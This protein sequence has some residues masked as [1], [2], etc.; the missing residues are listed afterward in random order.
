MRTC[1][2]FAIVE[3]MPENQNTYLVALGYTVEHMVEQV[4]AAMRDGWTLAGGVAVQGGYV[5]QAMTRPTPALHPS[6]AAEL[7]PDLKLYG[8][9][10][11]LSDPK[12]GPGHV[13]S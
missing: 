9:V 3:I 5:L 7:H 11:D 6:K 12:P 2:G 13:D 8:H 1:A 10:C 4:N